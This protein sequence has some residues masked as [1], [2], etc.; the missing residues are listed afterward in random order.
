MAAFDV[1][2]AS[3]MSIRPGLTHSHESRQQNLDELTEIGA[4]QYD[5]KH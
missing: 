2:P 1:T 3:K 4:E 5:L